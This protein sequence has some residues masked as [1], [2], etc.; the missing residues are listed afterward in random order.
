[1]KGKK[2]KKNNRPENRPENKKDIREY[3]RTIVFERDNY[4]CKVCHKKWTTNDV[5]PNAGKM[6]AHHITDR[7]HFPN[8]GYVLENGITVC[9]GKENS[10]HMKC[11]LFHISGGTKWNEG[12]HPDDL[13]ILINSSREKANKADEK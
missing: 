13:Y 10:C 11:E 4:T 6:N 7:H 5:D 9:D 3:F 2:E 1:M 12:L 8:G